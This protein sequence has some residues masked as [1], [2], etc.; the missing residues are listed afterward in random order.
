MSTLTRESAMQILQSRKAIQADGKYR[1]KVTNV[2]PY[3][4]EDGTPVSIVNFAG[5]TVHHLGEAKKAIQAGDYDAACNQCLTASPR[6]NGKDFTPVKGE[7]VDCIVE[8]ITTRNGVT[9]QFI[10]SMTPVATTVANQVNAATLFGVEEEVEADAS[11]ESGV[12]AEA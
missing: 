2:T 4:R 12:V 9:G 8:T 3:I 10:T 7:I 6:Q 5:M 1:L 11:V